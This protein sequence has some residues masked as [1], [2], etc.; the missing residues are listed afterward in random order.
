MSNYTAGKGIYV[1]IE[2]LGGTNF[3]IIGTCK[4]YNSALVYKSINCE[5]FGPVPLFD[6][7]EKYGGFKKKQQPS[8]PTQSIPQFNFPSLLQ[9]QQPQQQQ[10]PPQFNFPSF[11]QQQPQQQFNFPSSQQQPQQQV[12]YFNFLNGGS[13]KM[14]M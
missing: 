6:S 7:T 13:D 11:L 3:R 8:L 12:P 4:T 10:F 9:P 1:I 14:N 2:N 5:I